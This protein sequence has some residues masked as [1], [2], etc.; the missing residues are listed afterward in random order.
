MTSYLTMKRSSMLTSSR[1][2]LGERRRL[3]REYFLNALTLA[4]MKEAGAL[5][6][7]ARTAARRP[8]RPSLSA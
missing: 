2:S 5:G 6:T 1:R 8:E 4:L 3:L 7:P